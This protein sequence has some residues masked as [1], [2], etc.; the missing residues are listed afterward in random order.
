VLSEPLHPPLCNVDAG[1]NTTLCR[2][3]LRITTENPKHIESISE[4]YI[5]FFCLSCSIED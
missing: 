4:G 2:A 1:G 5:G 3:V